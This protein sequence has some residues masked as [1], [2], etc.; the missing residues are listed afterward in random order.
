MLTTQKIA[1]PEP[2][3]TPDD[4]VERAR[5]LRDRVRAEAPAAEAAGAYSPEL[6]QAFVEAGLFRILQP[7]RYGGYEFDLETFLKVILLIAEGDMGT[8]WNL[9]L[10]TAHV[11]QVCA[12]Y[13]EQ[14]QDE[15]FAHRDGYFSSPHRT[16][17]EGT[18]T[19]VDGGYRV[20]GSWGYA[21]GSS[22]GSHL[23]ATCMGPLPEDGTMGIIAPIVPM[24]QCTVLD[25]WGPES[26]TGLRSSGSNTVVVDDVFVP[27]HLVVNGNFLRNEHPPEGPQGFLVHKSPMYLGRTITIYYTELATLMTGGA[28]GAVKEFERLL[29]ERP[30]AMPPKIPRTESSDYLRWLGLAKRKAL[31]AEIL[32]LTVGR[33]Y[34]EYGERFIAEGVPFTDVEDSSLRSLAQQA[35]ELALQ[36]VEI[37]YRKGGVSQVKA[38]TVLDRIFRDISVATTH[39]VTNFEDGAEM[40]SRHDLGLP[41]GFVH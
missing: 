20:S 40:T 36:A 12:F 2:D 33:R 16:S 35:G 28:L 14:A 17:P 19:K 26:T 32:V 4:I 22:Y 41:M 37:C 15:L 25:D 8:G 7:R 11:L 5:V 27:D 1:I 31:A 3:L 6:H 34:R 9:S 39:P 13:S 18:A 21:S 30:T 38:G 24:E 10:G 29:V 23:I